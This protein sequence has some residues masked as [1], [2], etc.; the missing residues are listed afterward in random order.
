MMDY[1]GLREIVRRGVMLAAAEPETVRY[2]FRKRSGIQTY[3][4][5]QYAKMATTSGISGLGGWIVG[6]ALTAVATGNL[7][8]CVANMT[9]AYGYSIGVEPEK[10]DFIGVLAVWMGKMPEDVLG[11]IKGV[12]KQSR[13]PGLAVIAA[14]PAIERVSEEIFIKIARL[15]LPYIVE[16]LTAR[17]LLKIATNIAPIV[18]CGVLI[19]VVTNDYNNVKTAISK[20]YETKQRCAS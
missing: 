17:I 10:H 3:Y 5:I 15:L 8:R 18:S 14:K 11:Q 12:V 19:A 16:S 1:D 9:Y 4:R 7:L 6:S 2:R 13:A 20:Y